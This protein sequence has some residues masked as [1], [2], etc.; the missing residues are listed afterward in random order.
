M[1]FTQHKSS[2]SGNLYIVDTSKGRILLECG[3]LP[4]PLMKAIGHNLDFICC[5]LSHEHKDHCKS[6]QIVMDSGIDVYASSGTFNAI[7]NSIHHRA[8][9]VADKTLIK[10]KCGIQVLCFKTHHDAEEP[11]GFIIRDGDEYLLF[12]TDTCMVQQ[13]FGLKF[14]IIAI[15]CNYD[16]KILLDRMAR[17]DINEVLA[18][19]LLRSHHEKTTALNYLRNFC[20]LSNCTEIHLLH[21]SGD[22]INAEA[23]REEFEKELFI[24]VVTV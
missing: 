20:D 2:S 10:L 5:L 17:K 21:M 1:K 4:K 8:K 13:R 14:N 16:K 24:K 12:A 7:G 11:L 9:L 15:E 6:V 18:K 22:N 23:T 3:I 19:R